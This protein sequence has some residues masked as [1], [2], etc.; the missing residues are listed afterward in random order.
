MQ[1]SRT[2]LSCLLHVKGYA[3][4]RVGSAFGAAHDAKR[5]PTPP[6]STES[7]FTFPYSLRFGSCRLLGAFLISPLPPLV[8]KVLQTA[9]PLP[10]T[11]ITRLPRYYPPL[12]HP[13]VFGRLPGLSGYTTYLAPPISRRDEDGFS[14]CLACPCHRAAS[15]TPPEWAAASVR[16]RHPMLSSSDSRGLDLRGF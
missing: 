8:S 6:L 4:Y 5:A 3:T 15:T 13:L 14:S 7:A 9:G 16:M 1:I 12:R 11:G 2:T 10:S